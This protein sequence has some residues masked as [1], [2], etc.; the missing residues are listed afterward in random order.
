[1]NFIITFFFLVI[2]FIGIQVSSA[3]TIAI[4][5]GYLI[6]PSDNEIAENQLILIRNGKIV[7]VGNAAEAESADEIIDLSTSWV[8]PGLMDCHVHLTTNLSYRHADLHRMYVSESN[9]F[10]ALRGARNAALLL[11][12][13]FTTVKEIGND[14]DYAMAD[15]I[16]AIRNGWIKGPTIQYAGK[17]IAP[18]GGQIPGISPQNEGF[19]SLEFIDADTHDEIR[20][21]IRKNIYNGASTIKMVAGDHPGDIPQ[22]FYS[23]EDI[24][25]AVEE[26][27]RAG[28]RVTVHT[29]GAEAARNAINGS[30]AA[31]EHGFYLDQELLKLM[32]EKNTFL[33]GTDFYFNNWY[34]YGM[35]STAVQHMYD[36][37]RDRLSVAHQLGVKMAFGTDII[38]DLPGMNRLESNLVVLKTWKD[39]GIPS[40]DILQSMTSNAAE[41]LGMDQERGHIS[42]GYWADI[43]ALNENP[44][45]NI[46]NIKTVHFV[47]KEGVIIRSDK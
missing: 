5:A 8:L 38:I 27:K 28:I 43:V 1:M 12:G 4:K 7:E 3:Q 21:A 46:E 41:L 33:V 9:A 6:N 2:S 47:M 37:V 11:Q 18:Y 29:N 42:P 31:I 22:Y 16:R 14:G 45:E 35:D 25:F 32:R 30:A 20:K 13:G 17:I 15:V 40:M 34:A 39:A 26:A 19:W 36:L 23:Q 44:L 24:A 10:R